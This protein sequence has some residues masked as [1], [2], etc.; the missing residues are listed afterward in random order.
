MKRSILISAIALII[1]AGITAQVTTQ[2]QQQDK[3]QAGNQL[4]TQNQSQEQPQVQIREQSRLQDGSGLQTRTQTRDNAAKEEKKMLKA[5]KKAQKM[6]QK[7]ANH[8]RMVSETARNTESG[9]GKGE[10]V[11]IQARNKGQ[12]QQ[13]RIKT[14]NSAMNQAAN[15]GA[16]GNGMQTRVRI[17]AGSGA[18]RK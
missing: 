6:A 15:Q 7:N 2:N 3:V 18:G 4:Q 10:I 14:N 13:A 11:S 16:R 8:G 1:S 9:P 17:P 12:V 5:Q